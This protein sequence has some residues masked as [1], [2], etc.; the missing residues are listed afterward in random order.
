MLSRED[1]E[2]VCR[3]GPRTPMGDV[4]RRYWVPACLSSQLPKNDSDPL[5]LR[6]LGESLVAFRDSNGAVGLLDELCPHRRASLALGRVEDCGI[7]CL[8]HGW[9]FGVDGRVQDTPN[10]EGPKFKDRVKARS[11][12]VHE[13][14]GILWAYMG[15]PEKMPPPP[16]YAFM[17]VPDTHRVVFRINVKC[18]YLQLA[19]GGFD[20]SHVGILHSNMARPGWMAKEFTPNP[21][22]LNPAALAV[23]DNAPGLELEPTDFGFY[24]SAV[25]IAGK[26]ASGIERMNVRVVP[27]IMPSTRIIPSPATGFTV[28]ETPMDDESTSTYIIVSAD[29]PIER[30]KIRTILG[31]DDPRFYSEIDCNWHQSWDSNMGQNRSGMKENWSG[32]GGVQQEDAAMSLSMGPIVDRTEEH[33]VPADLAVVSLRRILISAAKAVA[34]AGDPVGANTDLSDVR[35]VDR[36]VSADSSWRELCPGHW[37]RSG[38]ARG[39]KAGEPA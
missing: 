4:F 7:R 14:A 15:P 24:Y 38:A 11:Y 10:Y 13:A 2:L 25:R 5:R 12:P 32:L 33:L 20:S 23:D 9:K 8:Y 39:E 26:D 17:D 6:L 30:S 19:E 22:V 28:F 29:V 1:N 34:A 36:T 27:F 18:N 31:L 37:V 3:I 21:D 35:A 16:R